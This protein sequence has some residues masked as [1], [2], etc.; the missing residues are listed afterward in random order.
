MVAIK[1][2]SHRFF[3]DHPIPNGQVM[4]EDDQVLV[5]MQL[6]PAVLAVAGHLVGQHAM[7][8]LTD[9]NP[10]SRLPFFDPRL[11]CDLETW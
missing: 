10:L 8:D 4:E 5:C 2:N 11:S 7:E 9:D 1:E 3:Q 6:S